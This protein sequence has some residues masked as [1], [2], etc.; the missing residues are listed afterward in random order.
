MVTTI[1]YQL[2]ARQEIEILRLSPATG[3]QN[4]N[5]LGNEFG[6][7]LRGNAG[8]NTLDGKGGAD[9]LEGGGGNDTYA[10]DHAGDQVFEGKGGGNDTVTAVTS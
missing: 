5:L 8:N 7:T 9:T 10:I 3:M 1:G 6:Q 4:L 2:T